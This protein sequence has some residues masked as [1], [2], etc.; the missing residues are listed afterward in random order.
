[1]VLAR[2][3]GDRS[4][5]AGNPSQNRLA[6]VLRQ[7]QRR[8]TGAYTGPATTPEPTVAATATQ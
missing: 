5:A 2:G 7:S 8:P 6:L 4:Q 3:L 1:M